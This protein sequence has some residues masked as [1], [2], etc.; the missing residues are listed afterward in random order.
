[1][2]FFQRKMRGKIK[3]ES[4]QQQISKLFYFI[5]LFLHVSVCLPNPIGIKKNMF[6]FPS[7]HLCSIVLVAK[8]FITVQL[9]IVARELNVE[10]DR[11]IEQENFFLVDWKHPK[12]IWIYGLKNQIAPKAGRHTKNNTEHWGCVCVCFLCKSIT[13]NPKKWR[14]FECSFEVCT[15]NTIKFIFNRKFYHQHLSTWAS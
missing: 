7:S 1:M 10:W 4:Q 14:A 3:S 5:F 12:H 15:R 13:Y 11:V 9:Y 6:H 2:V 8:V